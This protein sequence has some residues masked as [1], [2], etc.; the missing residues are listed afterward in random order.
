MTFMQRNC[1]TKFM[2]ACVMVLR[3]SHLSVYFVFF[4][5]LA[6]VGVDTDPFGIL[7]VSHVHLPFVSTPSQTISGAVRYH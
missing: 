3:L 5:S 2:L 4:S 7:A 6:Y 1:N